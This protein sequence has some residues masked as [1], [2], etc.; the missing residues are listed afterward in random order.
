MSF[1]KK[2][3]KK[4]KKLVTH[5]GSFHSDDIFVAA[6]LLI[7]LEK[8]GETGEITRT[9]DEE[10]IKNGD[11]VFDVGG[12]YDE[13]NNRFDHHQTLGVGKRE[14]GIAYSSFGLVW[15]KFGIEVA[16]S[17]ETA[18]FIEKKL[19]MSVDANDNGI[20]LF[21]SNFPDI[22]VYT[23][24]DVF[25]TFSP[26]ALEDMEKD[27]QFAKAL[28]WAK[29]IL[30]REIKKANDQTEVTK[31]IR[32]FY[33]KTEDKR[34]I[35]VDKPKVSRFEIWD[36]LQDFTEP[37]FAVSGDKEDWYAVAMRKEKDS[38]G[39]RKDFPALWAGLQKKELQ[40][41]TGVKD[42]VFCHNN[43]FLSAAKSKEGAIKLA[44][45][46]LLK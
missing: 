38:F 28:V 3:I 26:T 25:A 8:N 44:E 9:R 30:K 10:I 14:N 21:K 1:L 36:A 29:E 35:V 7:Y 23:I 43:L 39:N 16:G 46:A 22:S 4:N 24:Q 18:D 31:I 12:I 40:D 34:L 45:L 32:D 17:R 19:V 20:D 2:I 6:T 42:A 33:K 13:K 27:G 37:L 15:R 11:Y 5:D 41:A